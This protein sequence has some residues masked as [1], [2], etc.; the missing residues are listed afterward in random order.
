MEP[1]LNEKTNAYRYLDKL[2]E[3]PHPDDLDVIEFVAVP[4]TNLGP[5][6]TLVSGPE[7]S[8]VTHA[9]PPGAYDRE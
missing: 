1:R 7:P 5:D 3:F 6:A 8:H 9:F 2:S 4:S